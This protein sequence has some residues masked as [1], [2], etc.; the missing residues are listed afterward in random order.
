MNLLSIV[1]VSYKSRDLL[2]QCIGSIY[3]ETSDNIFEIIIVDNDSRDDSRAAVMHAYPAIRW[4]QLTYNAGFARANNEGIRQSPGSTVLLLNADTLIT[5]RAIEKCF[6]MLAASAYVAA[7]IQLLNEDGSEQISGLFDMRGG[8]NYLL[9]LPYLGRLVRNLGRMLKV[10]KP[11][12]TQQNA[13]TEVDWINGAFLMVKK[14]AIE[15]AGLMDEDFFL[16]A[17]EAEWCGRLRKTG[18]LCVFGS[19]TSTHLEGGIV[20]EQTGSS[21]KTKH[22]LF[23][24]K[25]LQIMLSNFVRIRKQFGAGWFLFV[26]FFYLLEIIVYP[27]GILIGKLFGKKHADDS[28]TSYRGY[29]RNMLL[30]LRHTGII[31][32]NRPHFYKV[33]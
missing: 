24:R 11:H 7:G 17:E 23:D 5:G 30:I 26:L 28:L 31:L 19:I 22:F 2:L 12:L 21:S 18:R 32:R 8:L 10:D 14:P 4:V 15:A 25:G 20:N 29:C 33:L 9:P 1:I 16:Y 27:V 6:Q 3:A 13:I